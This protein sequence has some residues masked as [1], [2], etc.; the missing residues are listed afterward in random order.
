MLKNKFSFLDKTV[1][2][3]DISM[4]FISMKLDGQLSEGSVIKAVGYP[5]TRQEDKINYLFT[6][7]NSLFIRQG[8]FYIGGMAGF[9][10]KSTDLTS[11]DTFV[12]KYDQKSENCSYFQSKKVN[13]TSETIENPKDLK[14]INIL[15]VGPNFKFD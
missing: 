2:N 7:A 15:E 3:A 5:K 6:G 9:T 1:K 14:T 8:I 4:K 10:E 12:F 13:L 11:G